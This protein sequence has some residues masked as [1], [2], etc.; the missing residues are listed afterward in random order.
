MMYEFKPDASLSFADFLRLMYSVY[1]TTEG[2]M[3]LIQIN[4][5]EAALKALPEEFSKYFWSKP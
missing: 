2:T 1:P 3:Q 5:N 4:I